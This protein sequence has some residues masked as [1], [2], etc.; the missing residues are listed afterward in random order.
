MNVHPTTKLSKFEYIKIESI[1]SEFQWDVFACQLFV[2]RCPP[3]Q[4][5]SVSLGILLAFLSHICVQLA[6]LFQ[7]VKLVPHFHSP[8]S[9]WNIEKHFVIERG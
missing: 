5:F 7:L 4:M 6:V 9:S 8:L 3:R 2:K 1:T